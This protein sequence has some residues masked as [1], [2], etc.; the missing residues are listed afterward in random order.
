MSDAKIETMVMITGREYEALRAENAAHNHAEVKYLV[1]IDELRA[2]VS[3]LNQ[4]FDARWSADMRAI[5]CWRK[6][7]PGNELVLPDHVNLCLW[8]MEERTRLTARVKELEG[9]LERIDRIEVYDEDARETLRS[10]LG[11][12]R[13]IARAA[14]KGKYQYAPPLPTVSYKPLFIG[15]ICPP[16]SEQTCQNPTCPRGPSAND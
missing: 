5:E 16:T 10:K 3:E 13:D 2:E 9:A 4:V 6:D 15:C 1:E 12:M 7:N 14:R 11:V 8:L